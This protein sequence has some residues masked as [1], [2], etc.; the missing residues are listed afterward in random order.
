MGTVR[1]VRNGRLT[2]STG[3]QSGA[4]VA[5][6]VRHPP[7]RT[8]RR[9]EGPSRG[10][11]PGGPRRD[12]RPVASDP[13]RPG[14]GLRGAPRLRLGGRSAGTARLRGPAS[15]R[16][17]PDGHPRGATRRSGWRRPAHRDPRRVRR[18][19]GPRPRLWPQHDGGVR[20]GRRDR[21]RVRRR[22]AARRDRLSR[23]AGRGAG[24]RQG[25]DD[26]GRPVR[27]ASTPRSC[28]TPATAATSR[29]GRSRPRTS[30]S[31]ITVSRP[32]PRPTRGWV[33]T[34]STR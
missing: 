28:T 7:S 5:V 10:S 9:R 22:R 32:T 27:R 17:P 25:A 3:S 21:A 20:R 13:R 18:A 4:P 23:H 8:A 6:V 24:E 31:C 11:R 14:A 34:P 29:A 19:A 30:T 12:P 33:A 2:R 26:R 16:Q 15:G 1:A